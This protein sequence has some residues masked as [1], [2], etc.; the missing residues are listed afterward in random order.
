[1]TLSAEDLQ[2]LKNMI[3]KKEI[4]FIEIDRILNNMFIPVIN[5]N[6]KFIEINSF[7]DIDQVI[8]NLLIS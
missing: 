6:S 2:S 3:L 4:D 5:E 8:I 7:I 1:V